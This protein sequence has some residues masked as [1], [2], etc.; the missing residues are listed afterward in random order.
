MKNFKKL[1][2][3]VMGATLIASA[4]IA[5]SASNIISPQ[6]DIN[7]EENINFIKEVTIL[8]INKDDK[9]ILIDESPLEVSSIHEVLLKVSDD[10]IIDWDSLNVG[11]RIT[12]TYSKAMTRSIPP[13][14][15]AVEISKI[16]SEISD[17][18]EKSPS[19]IKLNAVIDEINDDEKYKSILVTD[20]EQQNSQIS[21]NIDENTIIINADGTPINFSDLKESDKLN[22]VHSPAM[23]FSLP[24]QTYAYAVIVNN[25]QITIPQYIEVGK[26]ENNDNL[27][28]IENIDGDLI[29]SLTD[30]TEVV[31]FKTKNIVKA[32]DIKQGDRIFAWYDIVTASLPAQATANKVMLLPE[33]NLPTSPETEDAVM[34]LETSSPVSHLNDINTTKEINIETIK[35]VNNIVV[36]NE[37][38]SLNNELQ[39]LNN[40]T[41]IPVRQVAQELGFNVNWNAEASTATLDK[42]T[43]K[44]EVTVGNDSYSVTIGRALP[45]EPVSL[46]AAP[47]F[48]GDNLYVPVNLFDLISDNSVTVVDG[49]LNIN[50][51]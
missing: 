30:D 28:Q 26:V 7:L 34:T 48:I 2:A 3:I 51:K 6:K 33:I 38:L 27:V 47:I 10:T 49:I 43:V 21:L 4:S 41:M 29:V 15:N 23:T 9:T 42:G 32:T 50:I 17:T 31:P 39:S 36:N 45:S 44:T 8:E 14:S 1:T 11:D 35:D 13:Q 37:T 16:E 18:L 24:P 22:V 40:C 25:D 12:A 19:T 46:G 5:V 20:S